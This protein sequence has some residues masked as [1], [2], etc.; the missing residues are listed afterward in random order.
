MR[1]R[2]YGL[3]LRVAVAPSLFFKEGN[4]RSHQERWSYGRQEWDR[5]NQAGNTTGRDFFAA[6]IGERP[7]VWARILG[8]H[9]RRRARHQR[10]V[11]AGSECYGQAYRE[12]ANARGN[13]QRDRQLPYPGPSG[14]RI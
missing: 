11:G 8:D 9:V 12:R 7:G 1:L 3:A 5:F 4:V 13:H 6:R 2:P 14:W 10:W